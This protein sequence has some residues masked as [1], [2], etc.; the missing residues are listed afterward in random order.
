MVGDLSQKI[1]KLVMLGLKQPMTSS[2]NQRRKCLII[3]PHDSLKIGWDVIISIVLLTSCFTTP[4]NLA[5]AEIEEV[6]GWYQTIL[7][8]MDGSFAVDIIINFNSAY[9]SDT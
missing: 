5:F 3:Y 2:S 8:I 9:E 7:W 6:Y 1:D 4:F